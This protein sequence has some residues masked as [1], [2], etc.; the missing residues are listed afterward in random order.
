MTKR[1]TWTPLQRLKVFE[2]HAGLCHIC[3]GIIDGTREAWEIEHLIPLALGGDDDEGNV[4]PAHKACHSV[5]TSKDRG[6]IA[7]ANR[8]RAKHLGAGKAGTIPGSKGTRWKR[9]VDGTVVPR[10]D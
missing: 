2:A 7:K 9:K 1:R 8:V 6:Q 5:K 10:D 4:A 3:G